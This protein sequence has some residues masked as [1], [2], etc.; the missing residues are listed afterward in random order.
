MIET[1]E[2]GVKYVQMLCEKCEILHMKAT[3]SIGFLETVYFWLF[4]C[5]PLKELKTIIYRNW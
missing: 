1:L 5:K 4:H 2:N 3:V